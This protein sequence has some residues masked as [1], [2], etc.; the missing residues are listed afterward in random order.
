MALIC[1]LICTFKRFTHIY[2]VYDPAKC[3]VL[4]QPDQYPIQDDVD[5]SWI[6][7]LVMAPPGSQLKTLEYTDVSLGLGCGPGDGLQKN[8]GPH[9]DT[10]ARTPIAVTRSPTVCAWNQPGRRQHQEEKTL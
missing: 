8:I 7:D 2:F 5:L 10:T 3:N 9:R 6:D 1:L 4:P